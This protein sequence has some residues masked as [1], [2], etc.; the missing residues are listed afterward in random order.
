[1]NHR[2]FIAVDLPDAVQQGLA[3]LCCG[4]P[5]ARWVLPGQFHLTLR[6]IGEVDGATFKD[7][8]EVLA[9]VSVASFSLQLQGVG[10][11][12]PRGRPR[13]LWAGL[14]EVGGLQALQARVNAA[15]A[16]VGIAPDTRKYSPH[17]TLAR[18]RNT[19][20]ARVGRFLEEHGLYTSLPFEV[21][22]FVLYSSFLGASGAVHTA[23]AEYL[24]TGVKPEA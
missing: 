19:P 10:H 18:L 12:P 3:P 17:V 24:L 15:L 5:G 13:L 22:S 16:R 9:E 20:S 4:L 2:L 23:E 1:M 7:I 8:R 6:F 14:A 21:R 11:F